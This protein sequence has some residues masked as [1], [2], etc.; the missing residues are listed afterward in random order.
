[1]VPMM[2]PTFFGFK[3]ERAFVLFSIFSPEVTDLVTLCG[4]QDVN[5]CFV[6]QCF[7]IF[8]WYSILSHLFLVIFVPADTSDNVFRLMPIRLL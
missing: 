7:L 8:F 4:C 3:R 5:Y 1:M 2:M 6:F